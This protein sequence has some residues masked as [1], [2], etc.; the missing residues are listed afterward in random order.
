MQLEIYIVL[1]CLTCLRMT[2]GYLCDI[3]GNDKSWI[4]TGKN[5]ECNVK[6]ESLTVILHVQSSHLIHKAR[7]I[8]MMNTYRLW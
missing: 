1:V 8:F 6:Y 4:M 2:S 3:L 7:S 5:T